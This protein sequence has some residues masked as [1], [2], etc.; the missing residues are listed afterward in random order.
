MDEQYNK[1]R[2]DTVMFTLGTLS[3]KLDDIHEMV[4]KNHSEFSNII[5][6]LK[7]TDAKQSVLI[8][9]LMNWRARVRGI[10]SVVIA[11][12]AIIWGG[13]KMLGIKVG[14]Q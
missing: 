11:L 6:E 2:D 8:S 12:P 4:H 10:A 7:A 9:S 13:I 5:A 1:R 3:S 14:V